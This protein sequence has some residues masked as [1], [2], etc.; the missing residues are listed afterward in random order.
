MCRDGK[1]KRGFWYFDIWDEVY[2]WVGIFFIK[3]AKTYLVW[4][5]GSSS[6]GLQTGSEVNYESDQFANRATSI[7]DVVSL[8]QSL[9]AYASSMGV[10]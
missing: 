1:T 9:S 4:A 5:F 2:N 6:P 3:T 8:Q 7:N 10:I